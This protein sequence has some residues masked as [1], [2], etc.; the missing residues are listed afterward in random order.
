MIEARP[1]IARNKE[2]SVERLIQQSVYRKK[3]LKNLNA[4]PS[5]SEGLFV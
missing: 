3:K 4:L 2:R 1:S 5:G